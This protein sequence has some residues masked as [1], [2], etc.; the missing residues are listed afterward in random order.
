MALAGLLYQ[1]AKAA[2]YFPLLMVEGSL[3]PEI[4]IMRNPVQVNSS[5]VSGNRSLHPCPIV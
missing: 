3:S 1:V 5:G 2:L 4:L